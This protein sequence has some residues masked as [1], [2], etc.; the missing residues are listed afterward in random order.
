MQQ[1]SDDGDVDPTWVTCESCGDAPV[2]SMEY[3]THVECV[4]LSCS[5][6]TIDVTPCFGGHA[7]ESQGVWNVGGNVECVDCGATPSLAL[8]PYG[9][10]DG[11][12][13][14]CDCDMGHGVN[15]VLSDHDVAAVVVGDWSEF[16]NGALYGLD[17]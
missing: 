13:V 15:S 2:L 3:G 7:L 1:I 5:C 10:F 11:Y 17:G 9:I 4:E 16:D 8:D 12:A 6:Q 14:V